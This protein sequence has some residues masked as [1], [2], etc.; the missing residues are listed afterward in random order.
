MDRAL[1]IA[2]NLEGPEG[3][4]FQHLSGRGFLTITGVWV[5]QNLQGCSTTISTTSI[6]AAGARV[7]A[8]VGAWKHCMVP[9]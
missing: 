3:E 6:A 2:D 1:L 9:A 7:I 8:A 4:K 5:Q